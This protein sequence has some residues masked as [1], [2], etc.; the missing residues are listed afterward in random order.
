[1]G[2]VSQSNFTETIGQGLTPERT[3]SYRTRSIHTHLSGR[4]CRFACM[5]VLEAGVATT[6]QDYPGRT[7][8]WSVGVP[9]SG[10][11]DPLSLQ[12]APEILLFTSFARCT[13]YVM[14]ATFCATCR[15]SLQRI[16]SIICIKVDTL[17]GM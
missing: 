14:L 9:P 16:V 13:P 7:R 4:A 11:M 10:P 6:V 17:K 15:L 12:C 3:M 5:Q 1:M 2:H 8:L